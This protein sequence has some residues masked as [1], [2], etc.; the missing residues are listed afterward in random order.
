M[1]S[2]AACALVVAA[3][4]GSA[5]AQWFQLL[6][7]PSG[8]TGTI[9]VDGISGDG[10]VVLGR[11]LSDCNPTPLRWVRSPSA[12]VPEWLG[13]DNGLPRACSLDGQLIAG[14]TNCD[15]NPDA[16]TWAWTPSGG[17]TALSTLPINSFSFAYIIS[18]SA[19]GNVIAGYGLE[20]F[21]AEAE[22]AVKI[23]S[24]PLVRIAVV[25]TGGPLVSRNGS[26]VVFLGRPVGSPS[27]QRNLFRWTAPA[28]PLVQLTSVP[29]TTRLLSVS[30]DGS[31][32]FL[33]SGSGGWLQRY[34][35]AGG[36]QNVPGGCCQGVAYAA[37][38]DGSVVAGLTIRNNVSAAYIW[39]AANGT[40]FIDSILS[41]AGV[42]LQGISLS[43]ATAISDDGTTIVGS[44]SPR[45]WI[46]DLDYTPPPACDSDYNQ[47]GNADQDDVAYLVNV[48]SGGPNPTGRDPD[49]TLDGNVDQDDVAA[50][51]N[52]VAGG[53]CPV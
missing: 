22:V 7:T 49:F 34:T 43:A 37:T 41:A 21:G 51:I 29:L 5:S 52:V 30:A 53:P 17:L 6:D 40:R 50:L 39:D 24:A 4:A 16:L 33:Q 44:G 11:T 19:D 23:G 8:V 13:F 9:N 15:T 47:D 25:P 3:S 48:V 42:D 12:A 46:A 28:G 32:I 14:D 35:T 45:A 26:A 1:R 20:D 38:P 10:S 31:E 18:M 27:T 36:L 2:I